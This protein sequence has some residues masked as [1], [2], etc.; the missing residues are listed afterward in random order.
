MANEMEVK[1]AVGKMYNLKSG[2]EGLIN[3]LQ[4][5]TIEPDQAMQGVMD[6]SAKAFDD[7]QKQVN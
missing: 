4:A 7:Y 2:V 3:L 6:L 1:T 5:G